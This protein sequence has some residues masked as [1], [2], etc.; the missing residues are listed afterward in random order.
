MA[1]VTG[2]R[3]AIVGMAAL[4]P[5]AGSLEE[6][7]RNLVDGVDA[8]SEVPPNRWDPAFYDPDEA[9]LPD[10]L[11]CRRGGFVDDLATFDPLKFG[12]MPASV[13]D[14][15]PDQLIAL[16][17]AAAAIDDAGGPQRLPTGDRVGVI[18]GRGGTLSPAQARYA[19]RV[20]VPTQLV[21]VLREVLPDVD[22]DRIDL[23]RRRFAERLGRHQPEGTIGIVPNL[24]ASRIANRLNLRGPAYTVDAAC[25]SSLL[26]VDQAISELNSGRLDTVL[27][28]GVHHSH[29]I[30][31]WSVFSQLGA[32]SRQGRIRPFDSGADGLLIGEGT[33]IVVLKRMADALRDGDRVY[34]VIRGSGTSSDGRA[35]SMFNPAT[36]GQVLAIRR[37]WAAAGLDPAAPDALGL[38]E[39]H[40]TATHAGDT[41]ELATVA[42]V[43]GPH[44]GGPRPVIGSVKSMIGHAMPA[45]GVAGLI[46]AA[47]AV[48]RGVLLPTLHCDDP[49]P[50][51]AR[52]RFTPIATARPWESDGP[53]RAGVNAFGFGG[54][55]AHL[56]IEQAPQSADSHGTAPVGPVRGLEVD[57]PDEVL[58]LGAPDRAALAGLLDGD[59]AAVRAAGAARAR[60]H[61]TPV[62]G[63]RCRLGVVG[64]DARRLA[65][66]RRA[67]ATG[68]PWRG[69]RDV[70]FS[71][72]PLLGGTSGGRLAFVFP[73]LEAEFRPRTGDL[74]AHFGL[75][76]RD[77]SA[78]GVGHHGAGVVQ[79]GLMLDEALGRIGVRPDTAAGYSIG[80]WTASLTCGQVGMPSIDGFL[81]AFDADSVEGAGCAFV[82]VGAAAAKVAPLLDGYPD[83]VLSHDNTPSQ[84]V[85]NGPESQVDA[86]IP[87]LRRR[88]L[89]CQ[90]LPFRS[91]AHTP[92]FA[93]GLRAVGDALRGADLRTP[94]VPVWSATIAAPFPTDADLAHGL[95]VRHMLEP[96]RFR[97]LVEA[98]YAAGVRVFLQVGTGQL[99]S[100]I[101]DNL[102]GREHLAIPVNVAHR[103]GLN[104]LRRVAT[105]LW[106]EGGTPDLGA[107]LPKKARQG[108]ERTGPTLKLDLG[109]SLI[110]LGE[111]ADT[112]LR[113]APRAMAA[114]PAMPAAPAAPAPVAGNGTRPD[115]ADT[116]HTLNRLAVQSSAAAELAALLR[117]TAD[118]AVTVLETARQSGG[119]PPTA[120]AP[121]ATAP[122]T[123]PAAPA[124]SPAGPYRTTLQVSVETMPYLRDHCFFVMPRD[125]PHIVDRWPV[126]PAT[127]VVQ[128]MIDAVRRAVPGQR[129]IGVRDARFNRWI[130]AAPPQQIEITVTP[131]VAGSHTVQ[132]GPFARATVDVAADYPAQ[133]PEIWRHDPA[134]ERPTPIPADRMYTDRLLFHGPLFQAVTTVHALGDRHARGLLTTPTPPGALLDNA[135]QLIGNWLFATQS[136]R[137]VALP[138][139]LGHVRFFGPQPPA[140]TPVECVVR[141]RSID[142][143]QLVA[144]AQLEAGGQ[145]WAQ[146]EGAVDRR[147]DSQHTVKLA[148]RFPERHA[149]SLRQPEGWTMAF[150]YWTDLVTQ[151]M[152]A[153]AVLGDAA[154]ADYERQPPARRKQWLLGRIAVKDAVRFGLW[155]DGHTEVYPVELTVTNDPNGRPRMR[156]SALRDYRDFG[157]S[158]AHTGEI[159]VAIAK[160]RE[161]GTGPDAPG[162]GIDVAEITER[163]ESTVHFALSTV[164]RRLLASIGGDATEWFT[165]FWVAKEAAGKAEGTGL[166]GDPRRLA[167]V[168]ATPEA[169]TVEVAGRVYRVDQR[170]VNNPENLPPRQYVV[171]WTWGP[172]TP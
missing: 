146:I 126:V 71:P 148:E 168:A 144:D 16:Q 165:R 86:L 90:K 115:A 112:L 128:H 80:E 113:P 94:R 106:V 133:R 34:A 32:L 49:R 8:I 130:I 84:C 3:I 39:A 101:G 116:L 91:A 138:V 96:V 122:P 15:D 159:G 30:T 72:D 120:V 137:T 66:A 82:A 160:A 54:I 7:W 162:V 23:V 129:V 27:A 9:H 136:Y 70:W 161:R 56:V 97:E 121:A 147:F 44:R 20:R 73:G 5:S 67:V 134:T 163:P 167:V 6:Y 98:M 154:Y 145:V 158:L 68:A 65:V 95:F 10:R 74:A 79:L 45:A 157:V 150:D 59:D 52:T 25:A 118:N 76:D 28:G 42:E 69:A 17:V 63:E 1:D 13:G 109:G 171:G 48:Y 99:A 107:V 87:E 36:A 37:A 169:L 104:Q 170:I 77:W 35:A 108:P 14:I 172:E 88:N 26:A 156:T 155:D 132:F 83:V 149:M 75:A 89:L 47:L 135:L 18:I 124:P 123:R 140:G 114:T 166:D 57:E 24:A 38:L 151:G 153:R 117:E 12:I 152:T 11:Y 2:H 33:G 143:T 22:P 103:S 50:E 139:G 53:R 46:K 119:T 110:R 93:S 85:V 141:I 142:D 105:A 127:A 55:N 131:T 78:I 111:G 64:P 100:L 102:R 19:T 58:W 43:F 41:A 62:T 61:G 92:R 81:T 51:L 125:W 21:E 164:E 29:D 4:L 40:G 60:R 31:F